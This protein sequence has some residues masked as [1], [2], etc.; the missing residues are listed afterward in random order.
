MSSATSKRIYLTRHAQAE[1]NV[2]EDYE[3]HD[4]PL[5]AF[6][7]EQ[8]ARLYE[9]TKEN[10]QKSAQLL[11]TS[12]LRRTL[13]TTLIGYPDLKARLEAEGKPVVVL[14]QLQETNPYPSD[15]GSDREVL[16]SDPEFAS[17]FDLSLLT[18][19]W[20]KKEGFYAS[21]PES[22]ANRAKW[23]RRWLRDREEQEI[24]VVCHA[25]FLRYITDGFN[26][27]YKWANT[28]VAHFTF[29]V[30]DDEDAVLVKVEDVY[31]KA[32]PPVDSSSPA[33]ASS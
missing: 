5:T 10:I 25:A 30:D 13:S 27:G 8:A 9:N 17:K 29:L 22:L 15:R 24:V 11:V 4:A 14:P 1:H 12:G 7:R 26:S 6:G 28:Q 32:N 16:E 19:E 23:V 3:I 21:D 31:L 33:R 2:A 20:N 18:P